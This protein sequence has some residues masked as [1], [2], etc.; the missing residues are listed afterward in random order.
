MA[1]RGKVTLGNHL[2][3]KALTLCCVQ[4]HLGL[5]RH[6]RTVGQSAD[7][8]RRWVAWIGVDIHKAATF[9]SMIK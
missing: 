7:L 8:H 9:L 3:P 5:R 6:V 4:L 1:K 2:S